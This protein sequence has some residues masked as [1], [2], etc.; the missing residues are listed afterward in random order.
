MNPKF[1]RGQKVLITGHTGFKGSWLTVWLRRLG[2][3]VV[4]YSLAPLS[5]P[6]M[7]NIAHV[8][9][10]VTS[11]EGDVRDL[12]KVTAA[13]AE[14]SPEVVI[15]MAAQALVKTAYVDPVTTFTTNVVG[16]LNVLEA[17]RK[18][19]SVRATVCITSDKCYQNDE[20]VWGYRENDRM[21]GHDP[22][23]SSKGCAELLIS[24]YRDS[25]FNPEKLAEHGVGLAS[26][27]AGNV[28]GGGDWSKDRLVPD[29]MG[30]ITTGKP[31]LI[32]RPNAVR[33]WQFVLEPL[34][35]YLHLAERLYAEPARFAGA[36]NFGPDIEQIKPVQ[37]IVEYLTSHWGPTARWVLDG[38]V[39]PHE[40]HFLRLDC[41][42]AKSI[43][44]WRPALDLPTVLDWIVEWNRAVQAGE[45]LRAIT[46]AQ[47]DRYESLVESS[48]VEHA[49]SSQPLLQRAAS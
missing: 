32:R 24:A 3:E 12:A 39:H 11:I 7:Y 23:S 10:D 15:H 47:I 1:W 35:G 20:W 46:E 34:R 28:I 22:Y 9:D 16:T 26:T 30:A 49:F 4:G 14:H 2:A 29:I 31:V 18:T 37:W 40:D 48:A 45:N 44:G 8:G 21:G 25:Y 6:S 36:W 19:P 13:L 42:K 33:P 5:E 38:A 43:L 17:V 27:R 41:T